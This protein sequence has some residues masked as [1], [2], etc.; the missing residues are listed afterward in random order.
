MR[1]LWQQ[2]LLTHR[3]GNQGQLE[4]LRVASN[5][6]VIKNPV[7]PSLPSRAADKMRQRE[8]TLANMTGSANYRHEARS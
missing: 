4:L 6:K 3:C 1:S 8:D 5:V 2:H 7:L